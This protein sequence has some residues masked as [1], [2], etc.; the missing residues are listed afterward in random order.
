MGAYRQTAMTG[1]RS[2]WLELAMDRIILVAGVLLLISQ[3]GQCNHDAKRL[4]DDLLRKSE[5]NKLIRPVQN[6]TNK[7]SIKLG[8]KLTQ[9]IKVVSTV[10]DSLPPSTSQYLQYFHCVANKYVSSVA[11][12]QA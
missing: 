11:Y 9:L 3:V 7:L 6:S 10:L 2:T 8:L 1:M 4:F 5:Y 12:E